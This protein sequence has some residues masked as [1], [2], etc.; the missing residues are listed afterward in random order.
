MRI[1]CVIVLYKTTIYEAI[2]YKSCIRHC[3][4]DKSFGVF[5]Y[6]NS[7]VAMHSVVEMESKRIKYVHDGHNS[8]VSKAY[9]SGAEYAKTKQFDWILLL[10]QDTHFPRELIS[11]IKTTYRK[12]PTLNLIIPNVVYKNNMP[13]S[14][15]K[16]N[17]FGNNPI[18]LQEG[19][20]SLK[21]YMPVNSGAC[22]RLD[23]FCKAGGYNP[24]IRLDF[25]DFDFFSRFCEVSPSF[26]IM[27]LSASQSFSNE[28]YDGEKL[29]YRFQ[30]Y[31]EG[32]KEAMNNKLIGRSTLIRMIRH[33]LALTIRTKSTFFFKYL[34]KNI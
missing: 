30:F 16:R 20:Y 23:H 10:D 33:T 5:V 28:E 29:K 14:P 24:Q 1:L 18:S 4:D 19:I 22:I 2:S 32:G 3:W 31:V 34:I 9:N 15:V 8:G 25:A 27:G 7:P 13:F 17:L 6:D 12:N 11:S 26:Y 21:D